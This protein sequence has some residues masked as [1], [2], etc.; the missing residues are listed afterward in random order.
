MKFTIFLCPIGSI[1]RYLFIN[2]NPIIMKKILLFLISL[3]GGATLWAQSVT[4]TF[5]GREQNNARVQLDRVVIANLSRGWQETIAF[6]DTVYTLNI[7]VGVEEYATEDE[8]KVMPNPF[9]GATRVNLSS[10]DNERARIIIVDMQG[11]IYAQYM[12]QLNAGDNYFNISLSTPQMYILTVQTPTRRQ[13]LKMVNTGHGGSDRIM[14]T[15]NTYKPRTLQLKATST[16]DFLPGDYMRYIGYAT[17]DSIVRQSAVIAQSQ[18]ADE[19]LTLEFFA[20]DAVPCPGMPTVTDHEG[21]VYHTVQIGSQCW[22]RENMRCVTSPTTGTYLIV[23]ENTPYTCTGKQAHWVNGDSATYAPLGYGVLYNWNAAVDTFNTAYGELHVDTTRLHPVWA[24]FTGH[25]RGICPEGW[26]VPSYWEWEKMEN[27]LYSQSDYWCGNNSSYIGKSLASQTGWRDTT[28]ICHPGNDPAAN[29]ATGFSA[30]PAGYNYAPT[31]YAIGLGVCFWSSSRRSFNAPCAWE[32]A[33]NNYDGRLGQWEDPDNGFS[34]RCVRDDTFEEVT[35]EEEQGTPCPGTPTVTDHEGNV[36]HTVQIGSQCWTK[37]NMRCETSP[38][39][40]TRFVN[41]T[42]V[43]NGSSCYPPETGAFWP[44]CDSLGNAGNDLGLLYYWDVALDTI[45]AAS[46]VTFTGFRRGICPQGWHVPSN[47]E[48]QALADYVSSQSEWFCGGDPVNNAK[49]LASQMGWLTSDA[50]CSI[51]NDP[52]ANNATG[53]TARPVY[54]LYGGGQYVY[55]ISREMGLYGQ[56]NYSGRRFSSSSSASLVASSVRCLKDYS[57]MEVSTAA[58]TTITDSTAESGGEVVACGGAQVLAKGVC[59]SEQPNPTVA[60]SHTDEGAGEG[61]FTSVM[62]GLQPYRHYYVRAY[63][64]SADNTLYGEE[65]NLITAPSC[66]GI[67]T[68]TDVDGNVYNTV[69][70]GNQCWMKENMRTT[71]YADSTE[72]LSP[73]S[74]GGYESNVFSYGYLY[75][76]FEATNGISSSTAIPFV[77]GICPEGW[78]IPSDAEWT[79]LTD[80]VSSQSHFSC[81]NDNANIAKALASNYGWYSSASACAVGNDLDANNL[82]GFNICPAGVYNYGPTNFGYSALLWSSTRFDTDIAWVRSLYY[83]N[84]TVNRYTYYIS[85]KLSVR[86]LKDYGTM[87]VSTTAVTNITDSTAESGGEVVCYEGMQVLSKGICWG[88]QP[89]PTLANSHT[90]EG[91]GEGSFTR[92][93]T[94]LTPSTSYYVRSYAFSSTDTVYGNEVSFITLCPSTLTDIDGNT[95]NVLQFGRQCWMKENLRTTRYAD[96]T[97]IPALSTSSNTPS[98]Y[99]PNDNEDNVEIYGYLYNWHA[100]MHNDTTSTANP[101][102]VQGVCPDGWHVPSIAEWNQLTDYVGSQ[103]EYV[104]ETNNYNVAKALADTTGWDYSSNTCAV[105]NAPSSNNATGFR[106]LPVGTYYGGGYYSF[107]DAAEFWTATEYNSSRGRYCSLVYDRSYVYTNA[108]PFKY[109][110][111]SVRCVRD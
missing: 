44:N 84:N 10:L 79:Q 91:A 29:N 71:H 95:Y 57:T 107:G 11:R 19:T 9:D 80:Y 86:C 41:N 60:D 13:S 38:S 49:A 5:T 105:G 96:N 34:V 33:I 27:Y 40:G 106:A 62:T 4:L 75:S 104:C 23:P 28:V 47:A 70:I 52:S 15:G 43:L 109:R 20:A 66:P 55:Y 45:G 99:A 37:E 21:N 36:Y 77:Q 81:G 76:W 74:P 89:N 25:R 87:G 83:D 102:G 65:M 92:E 82:T 51:G 24:F 22:T 30:M 68:I 50:A 8:M 7:G 12:G 16:H 58:V 35:A 6:P 88:E 69:Q 64:V 93:M 59:W 73:G 67:P 2:Q 53:F 78:H 103:S 85:Q 94:A 97:E 98:R 54:S 1:K 56:L 63:A 18:S 17:I 90:D 110:G 31:Y 111:L 61:S 26:H 48:W 46:T 14:Y 3:L 108:Y 42:L 32:M 100:V 72:I 101:S 39:T